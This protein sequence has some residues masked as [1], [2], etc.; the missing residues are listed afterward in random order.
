MI[1]KQHGLVTAS[2]A[3]DMPPDESS[4]QWLPVATA[5]AP[6]SSK[7]LA[8]N[9]KGVVDCRHWWDNVTILNAC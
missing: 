4:A 2:G 8:V 9:P 1:R 5:E 3:A 7:Y 6:K